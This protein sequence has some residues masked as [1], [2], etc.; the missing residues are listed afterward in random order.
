[1]TFLRVDVHESGRR[2][3]QRCAYLSAFLQR[4]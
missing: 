2:G 1:L 4:A 3:Y